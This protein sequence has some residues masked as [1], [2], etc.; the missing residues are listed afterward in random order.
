L[1]FLEADQERCIAEQK[2]LVTVEAPTFAEEKRAQ[3]YAEHLQELGLQDVHIDSHGNVL[4]TR[5]GKGNGPKVLLEAHLDT[6]FPFGTNVTPVERDGKIFAPGI[7]DD[8]RGLTA[9]LS[10][11]RGLQAAGIETRGDIVFAGTVCEEGMGGMQGMKKLL[12]DNPDIAATISIDGSGCDTI[13]Y[14]G[15]GIRNFEV[16]YTGPGGH[17]YGAFGTPSPLHAAARTIARLSDMQPPK[18]PKTTFTVSLMEAGHAI[19]AIAQKAVFKINMRSDD[20]T[21]LEQLQAQALA[22]FE[23]GAKE[24]NERWASNAVTVEYKMILDVPAGV[25]PADCGIVQAAW[26][27]TECLGISPRLIPGGCTNTNMPIS[28]GIPAVTLGRGGKEGGV[29]SLDEWFD[30]EGTYRC[31]QRS[32]LLLLALAGVKGETESL[33]INR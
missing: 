21:E 12:Q 7:C 5:K 27:A 24:E 14:E 32:F 31:P 22:I 20:P 10:V 15:T 4:G 25:Q 30:P 18:L 16:T 28:L 9:N 11:I 33:I 29:H 3:F 19:H 2:V 26:Q 6:V 13:I 8:T 1:K 23:Q 17:A